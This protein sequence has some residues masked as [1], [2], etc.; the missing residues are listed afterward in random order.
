MAIEPINLTLGKTIHLETSG[1]YEVVQ[2]IYPLNPSTGR[3]LYKIKDIVTHLEFA[4]KIFDLK[5]NKRQELER[6]M[7][8]LN[9]ANHYPEVFPRCQQFGLM[10]NDWAFLRLDWLAG[11]TLSSAITAPPADQY[12][13]KT[14]IEILQYLCRAVE[15]LHKCRLLHR[16][17]KPDNVLLRNKRNPHAGLMLI[18]LGLGSQDRVG[19]E[20]G[21]FG[22]QAPEQS[23]NRE[24]QLNEAVDIFAVGQIGWWLLTGTPRHDAYPNLDYTD[25]ENEGMQPLTKVQPLANK[26]LGDLLE[27]AMAYKPQQRFKNI[28]QLRQALERIKI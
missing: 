19:V 2:C 27:K 13:L 25:W 24:F 3:A 21:T 22:Y 23:G 9:L 5:L 17:L 4:L 18:D 8:A 20:E 16:D 11:A 7:V 28:Q 14:R 1:Q 10:G 6:E 26:A 12:D 15:K